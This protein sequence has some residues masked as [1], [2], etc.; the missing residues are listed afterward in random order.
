MQSM[1][2]VYDFNQTSAVYRL[3]LVEGFLH[4]EL[5]LQLLC[6]YMHMV[7]SFYVN[8]LAYMTEAGVLMCLHRFM[9]N[10]LQ[11]GMYKEQSWNRSFTS[12]R[13]WRY[14]L[15]FNSIHL[16]RIFQNHSWMS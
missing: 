8:I 14:R 5:G 9:S 7:C 4:L 12:I 10:D 6:Q 3:I 15:G 11:H 13:L 16:A 1:K 2:A